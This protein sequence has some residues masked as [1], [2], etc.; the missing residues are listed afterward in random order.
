MSA[1]ATV[2][3]ILS[4]AKIHADQR[5][6]GSYIT[7]STEGLLLVNRSI[8]WLRS[9][10]VA[11]HGMNAFCTDTTFATV[12]DQS[13]YD[14]PTNHAETTALHVQWGTRRTEQL[15]PLEWDE[16]AALDNNGQWFQGSYKGYDVRGGQIRI[17]PAPTSVETVRHDYYTCHVDL[18]QYD[19]ITMYYDGWRE[20]VEMDVACR[21]LEMQELDCERL[22]TRR[23][24]QLGTVLR[25]VE[26]RVN[27]YVAQCVDV[28]PEGGYH[29][30][31]PDYRG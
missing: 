16:W 10:I 12:A 28:H 31:W 8:E 19:S 2:S 22:M 13:G 11:V 29:R 21:I 9:E 5:S 7:D 1:A 3:E 24:R 30:W 27:R 4:A 14:L 23:D 6:D 15:H 26:N 18:T 25:N 17:R 20:C